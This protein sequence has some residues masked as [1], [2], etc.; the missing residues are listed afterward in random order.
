MACAGVTL[1]RSAV[2]TRL[3]T[4]DGNAGV[5]WEYL[6]GSWKGLAAKAPDNKTISVVATYL[7]VHRTTSSL[8]VKKGA[9][10]SDWPYQR[11]YKHEAARSDQHDWAANLALYDCGPAQQLYRS[12]SPSE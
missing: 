5:M 6:R 7:K 12:K 1:P 8:R 4:T 10:T 11:W 9:W 3:H 2:H